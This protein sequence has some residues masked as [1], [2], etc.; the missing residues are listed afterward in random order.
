MLR[1]LPGGACGSYFFAGM[2]KAMQ[3]SLLFSTPALR[4]RCYD[5]ELLPLSRYAAA[6]NVFRCCA[7]ASPLLPGD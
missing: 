4:S 1:H 6:P 2:K 7:I 3:A 5:A